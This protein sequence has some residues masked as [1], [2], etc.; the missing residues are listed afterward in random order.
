PSG[1][2]L[3]QGSFHRIDLLDADTRQPIHSIGD[4]QGKINALHFSSDGKFLVAASGITGH[5]GL[6][7]V[8]N[9]RSGEKQGEYG[10]N[11]HRDLLFDAELSPDSR[12]LAT[13]GYD[14]RV[15]LWDR[16][17]G[18]R[19]R[20]IE[21][22]NGAIYDL[23]FSPDGKVLASASADETVKLWAVDSGQRLDTLNQPEK[24]QYVTVFHPSGK[25]L[26]AA[27]ADSRIR[28]YQF[29]S[30]EKPGTNPLLQARFAHEGAIVALAVSR[31]GRWLASAA[32]D[33][34]LRLW[35]LPDLLPARDYPTQSDVVAAIAIDGNQQILTVSRLDGTVGHLPLE[36]TAASGPADEYSSTPPSALELASAE[37]VSVEEKEPNNVIEK[38]QV[39]DGSSVID[40][41]IASEGDEDIYRF[42]A[43]AGSEW[44]M[45]IRA[46][47][48]KSPLDS[49]IAIQN[50]QGRPVKQVKL[51]AVRDT[52]FTFRGKDSKASGDFRLHNWEEM[53]LNEYLYANGEVV[54]LWLYPRGPDSGFIVYPGSGNRF[55]YFNTTART[56]AL[57]APC[58]IVHPFPPDK[59]LV[60]NG[61][62]VFDIYYENDDDAQRRWDR[63]SFL[64]FQSPKD[65]DYHV[66]VSDVRQ[67][68]GEDFTYQLVIRPRRP[69][70][71]VTVEGSN[72][73]VNAGSGKEFKVRA[74]RIDGFE[75]P[76][77]IEITNVPSG[78]HIPSPLIIQA[79]QEMATGLINA[80][81]DAS[82]PGPDSPKTR[83][84]ATATIGDREVRKEIGAL[85]EMKLAPSP[86]VLATI[87]PD[88][89]SDSGPWSPDKPYELTIRPGETITARVKIH[90][91][92]FNARVGFG[93]E[94]SGR[95][96]PHGVY[97]DNIGLNGLLIPE[98]E[99]E[100]QFFITAAK[101]VP[102][103]RR[104]I[105]LRAAVEGNQASWPVILNVV[106]RKETA[107]NP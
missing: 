96:F 58:Y 54:K 3:A 60:P 59:K 19:L 64:L 10:S 37:A 29:R 88:S 97:V 92:D 27:G 1:E 28:M 46:A 13:A 94:D 61:L 90:R 43:P 4:L 34:S 72:P 84:V 86:K 67:F 104:T 25:M 85:D 14:R 103:T 16:A 73:T 42:H 36:V 80:R 105:H 100:R 35:S 5:S 95:N 32:E 55:N 89:E 7:T 11:I 106:D 9:A 98:G 83:L 48:N 76:I 52:W 12:L 78:F 20:T 18:K 69:D 56:H 71:K 87:L 62:P 107:A 91:R 102:P 23:A 39:L 30:R 22:H 40:G 75:G 66:T 21:G 57:G 82:A 26:F 99:T 45:E 6:A 15:Q 44:A 33:R 79:G 101:W 24:E 47:R 2:L 77:R 74:Q 68:G 17:S 49:K 38:A 81:T 65:D 31:D 50:S 63:D 41:L 93:N 51:Q 53:E 70:F 8:W